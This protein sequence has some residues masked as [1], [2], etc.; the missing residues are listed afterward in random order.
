MLLRILVVLVLPQL[1]IDIGSAHGV[2]GLPMLVL[3]ILY[4]VFFFWLL[5]IFGIVCLDI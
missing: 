2:V 1:Q 3:L 5:C 4:F